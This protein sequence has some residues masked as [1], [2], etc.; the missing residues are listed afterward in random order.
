[1]TYLEKTNQE[2]F[3]VAMTA[4]LHE[5][6]CKHLLRVDKQEDVTFA[7]YKPS[8]GKTRFTALIHQVIFPKDGDRIVQGN[9]KIMPQYF[10]RACQLAT[11]AESGLVLLHSHTG[12]GWQGMSLDD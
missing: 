7:L 12:P 6:L 8:S 2:E 1:M 4:D 5:I 9:V 11:A 3:S 10:K